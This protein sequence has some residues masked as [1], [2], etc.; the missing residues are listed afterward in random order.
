MLYEMVAGRC[1]FVG[2]SRSDVVAAILDR[3]PISP[4]RFDPGVAPDLQR[5]IG[6]ALRK[7]R[8]QRYQG[9]KDLLRDLQTLRDDAAAQPRSSGEHEPSEGAAARPAT[10]ASAAPTTARPPRPPST[11]VVS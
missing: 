6:K 1:P 2:Q 5:I 4:T 8:E 7:D 11:S 3:E 9:M 10:S